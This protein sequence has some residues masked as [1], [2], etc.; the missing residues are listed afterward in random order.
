MSVI[1]KDRV[2]FR[3]SEVNAMAALPPLQR[4][5]TFGDYVC[6]KGELVARIPTLSDFLAQSFEHNVSDKDRDFLTACALYDAHMGW[7]ACEV[8]GPEG[9]F[10]AVIHVAMCF[11]I[12][13]Q[14]HNA[15]AAVGCD[16][17]RLNPSDQQALN[18]FI[19]VDQ[20]ST[21]EWTNG[22]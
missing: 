15:M 19:E 10:P 14:V 6:I 18:Q 4:E 12:N 16:A 17:E 13:Q 22:N 5:I 3:Q 20:A 2:H 21:K 9:T 11:P 1:W 7:F 8:T